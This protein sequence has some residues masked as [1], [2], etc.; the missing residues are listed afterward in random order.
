ME[1]IT[2]V[3]DDDDDLRAVAHFL[4]TSQFSDNFDD[5]AK[6]RIKKLAMKYCVRKIA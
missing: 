3:P 5:E 2:D 1:A 4:E 6:R